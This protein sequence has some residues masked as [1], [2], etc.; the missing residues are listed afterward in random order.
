MMVFY[1]YSSGGT[2][3]VKV[4]PCLLFGKPMY[5]AITNY[6]Y[7][8]NG[9]MIQVCKSDPTTKKQKL[10]TISIRDI[11]MGVMKDTMVD[12]RK[13]GDIKG[14]INKYYFLTSDKIEDLESEGYS[15][16]SIIGNIMYALEDTLKHNPIETA[17]SLGI[18][19]RVIEA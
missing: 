16:L 12:S 9:G 19:I 6:Y 8:N 13:S 17:K 2:Y 3:E 4:N 14:F 1:P 7:P 18:N 11:V 15:D 10:I 5:E